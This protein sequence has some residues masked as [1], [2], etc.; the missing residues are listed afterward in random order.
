MWLLFV[1]Q[2][3]RLLCLIALPIM[4]DE[5]PLKQPQ[6]LGVGTSFWLPY[7]SM[8]QQPRF[9]CVELAFWLPYMSLL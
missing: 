5:L 3:L 7:M 2:K 8:L 6:F 4:P 1:F 9:L